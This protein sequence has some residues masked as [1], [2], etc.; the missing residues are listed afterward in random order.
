[1][2]IFSP[3]ILQGQRK[4]GDTCSYLTYMQGGM[5]KIEIEISNAMLGQNVNAICPLSYMYLSCKQHIVTCL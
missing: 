5:D 1:M 3:H 4:K 2:T